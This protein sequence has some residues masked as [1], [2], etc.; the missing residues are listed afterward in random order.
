[1]A[2]DIILRNVYVRMTVD[3]RRKYVVI[4][5]INKRGQFKWTNTDLLDS[6]GMPLPGLFFV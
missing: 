1:M 4:G 2:R 5:Y 3:G 6:K